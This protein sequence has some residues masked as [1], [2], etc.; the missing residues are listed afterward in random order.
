MQR[1]P[2]LSYGVRRVV[3]YGSRAGE[4]VR[5]RRGSGHRQFWTKHAVGIPYVRVR[6]PVP[7]RT[8]ELSAGIRVGRRGILLTKS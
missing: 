3:G 4:A 5:R 7:S 6:Q 2:R 1:D 8:V